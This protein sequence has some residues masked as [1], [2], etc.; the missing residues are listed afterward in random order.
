[1]TSNAAKDLCI[2]LLSARGQTLI[3]LSLALLFHGLN[4]RNTHLSLLSIPFFSNPAL[5]WTILRGLVV[6]VI[7]PYIPFVNVYVFSQ[8]PIDAVQWVVI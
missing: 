8:K 6:T 1:M 5:L 4:C 2:G 7:T 3:F